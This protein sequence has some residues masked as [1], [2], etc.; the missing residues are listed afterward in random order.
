[1]RKARE[2]YMGLIDA[3][4]YLLPTPEGNS[5]RAAIDH[6]AVD[7]ALAAAKEDKALMDLVLGLHRT[8]RRHRAKMMSPSS[9][10]DALREVIDWHGEAKRL[11]EKLL[12]LLRKHPS[13]L[14]L[15]GSV[16]GHHLHLMQKR[17][18]ATE[19]PFVRGNIMISMQ[20]CT[21]EFQVTDTTWIEAARMAAEK[22]VGETAMP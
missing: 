12:P 7:I 13:A 22:L 6:E 1:M 8:D 10:R 21:E 5:L 2:E 11:S 4:N 3:R 18:E 14:K 20:M 19:S 9:G 16:K 15:E 17:L